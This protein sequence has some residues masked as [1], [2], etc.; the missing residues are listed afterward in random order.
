ML[1]P[2]AFNGMLESTADEWRPQPG[3][4]SALIMAERVFGGRTGDFDS[5]WYLFWPDVNSGVSV[6]YK[7]G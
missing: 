4:V 2:N 7:F 6:L 3:Y 5:D 1:F